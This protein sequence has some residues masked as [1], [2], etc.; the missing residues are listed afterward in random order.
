MLTSIKANVLI[1]NG[2]FLP[3]LKRLTDE[4]TWQRIMAVRWGA[5]VSGVGGTEV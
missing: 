1:Y 5:S 3:A 4:L 2:M